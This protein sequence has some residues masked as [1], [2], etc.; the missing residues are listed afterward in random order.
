[1]LAL[2][3]I[4]LHG[5][6]RVRDL[7]MLL[8]HGYSGPVNIDLCDDGISGVFE[9]EI[10]LL[11]QVLRKQEQEQHKNK[12]TSLGISFYS[13]LKHEAKALCDVLRYNS[14]ILS[15]YLSYNDIDEGGAV[16]LSDMLYCNNTITRLNLGWNNIPDY[17]VI[18]LSEALRGN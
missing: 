15:L 17:G 9:I 13:I 4:A 5:S 3:G 18:K 14:T 11:I 16:A 12:I 1:M 6:I 2:R 8:P 7:Q 10:T